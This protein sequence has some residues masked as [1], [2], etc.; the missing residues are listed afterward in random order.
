M[1]NATSRL[2][3]VLLNS[4]TVVHLPPGHAIEPD[5]V[6]IENNAKVRKLRD[7]LV[8]AVTGQDG[9]A[10]DTEAVARPAEDPDDLDGPT[11]R[12]RQTSA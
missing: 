9:A 6:E 12:R 3:T 11:S 8:I 2:V 1:A 4:G 7:S 10:V 5:P